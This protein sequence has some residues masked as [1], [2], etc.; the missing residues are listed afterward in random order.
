MAFG[1][2]FVISMKSSQFPIFDF[3]KESL[4]RVQDRGE[5]HNGRTEEI[6]FRRLEIVE[7]IVGEQGGEHDRNGCG[8]TFGECEKLMSKLLKFLGFPPTFEEALEEGLKKNL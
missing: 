4:N 2:Q 1:G 8:E 7:Q 6:A 3:S 5:N